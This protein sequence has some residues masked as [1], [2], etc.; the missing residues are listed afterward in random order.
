MY[1]ICPTH[2]IL[3]DFVIQK[4]HTNYEAPKCA[5]FSI[6][7]LFTS[8]CVQLSLSAPYFETLLAYVLPLK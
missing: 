6:L 7:L 3:P 4:K 5:I 2:L 8:S 1:A